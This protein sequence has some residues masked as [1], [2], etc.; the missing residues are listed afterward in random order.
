MPRAKRTPE[1]FSEDTASFS[2]AI[3]NYVGDRVTVSNPTI[4]DYVM[5]Y[6]SNRE[7]ALRL[8]EAKGIKFNSAMRQ[9]QRMMKNPNLKVTPATQEALGTLTAT[10]TPVHIDIQGWYNVS[11]Y[12]RYGKFSHT[13]T[14]QQM[15]NI[16]G[17]TQSE[18]NNAGIAAFMQ[19]YGISHFTPMFA[20][21][22][23]DVSITPA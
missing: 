3:R 22:E 21:S 6:G 20:T 10:S 5:H 8:A 7:V 23:L 19:A 11:D 2:K 15:T 17:A 18:G 9:V 1:T 16:I 13:V 4:K 12:W 14:P